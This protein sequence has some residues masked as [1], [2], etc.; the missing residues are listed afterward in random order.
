MSREILRVEN[1]RVYYSGGSRDVKAVDGVDLSVIQGEILGL[2]GESGC[3]KTTL[4]NAILRLIKPPGR[5]VG[6]RILFDGIDILKLSDEEFRK[7]R[8]KMISYI[9]Q[10]SMNALNPV[11]RIRDQIADVIKTHEGKVDEDDLERR[12]EDALRNVGLPASV[13]RMYPV[14]LSGGMRQRVVIAMAL[15][16]GPKMIVA[17]EPT[18]ALDVVT[19]KGILDLLTDIREKHGVTIMLITH[20]MAVHAETADRIAVMYAGKVVEV[21]PTDEIFSEPLHPY[22]KMLI[23][24]IPVIGRSKRLTGIPGLPPDLSNPPPGCRFHP[25][26]PFAMDICRKEEP[27]PIR[28]GNR[29]VSCHLYG[30]KI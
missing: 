21:S 6:G 14:E 26:C 20:D 3:G 4:A 8:W 7:I 23:N 24:S 13:S 28:L 2:A 22:T 19:Q 25:R 1:L 16:L 10:S 5:I 18:T 11:M 27:K 30:E 15:M 12:V 17:D 9:P 29:I